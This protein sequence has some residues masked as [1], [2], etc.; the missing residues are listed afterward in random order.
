[1]R[2]YIINVLLRYD[3]FNP[4]VEI[5]SQSKAPRNASW[6]INAHPRHPRACIRCASVVREEDGGKLELHDYPPA[7]SR[8]SAFRRNRSRGWIT[9][10]ND[11]RSGSIWLNSYQRPRVGIALLPLLHLD[12][13]ACFRTND[14]YNPVYN[15][16]CDSRREFP[17]LMDVNMWVSLGCSNA[18]TYALQLSW[19]FARSHLSKDENCSP[20]LESFENAAPISRG[21]LTGQRR[22]RWYG[23]G[24]EVMQKMCTVNRLARATGSHEH[25]RL[26]CVGSQHISVGG[27]SRGVDMGWHVFLFATT[28]HLNHLCDKMGIFREWLV[29]HSI[30]FSFSKK[31]QEI[32]CKP[33][34]FCYSLIQSHPLQP[35]A[36]MGLR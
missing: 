35:A 30:V 31:K 16:C 34:S 4:I 10:W 1:M 19:L 13:K 33:L 24:T 2:Y 27:L 3:R 25:Q 14:L 11:W 12:K 32:F 20:I 9:S 5:V 8:W 7:T 21:K 26:V 36:D 29:D 6:G 22:L 15:F 17:L 28:E 18:S 23:S